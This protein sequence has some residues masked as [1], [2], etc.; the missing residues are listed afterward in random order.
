M[1]RNSFALE[2]I[3]NRNIASLCYLD[4]IRLDIKFYLFDNT[5]VLIGQDHRNIL[6][7]VTVPEHGCFRV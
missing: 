7:T 2:L 1:E 5:P 6:K 3:N 4:I